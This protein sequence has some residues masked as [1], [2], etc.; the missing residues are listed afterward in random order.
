[1][2]LITDCGTPI[3]SPSSIW[4]RFGRLA[5]RGEAFGIDLVGGDHL[6]VGLGRG[7]GDAGDGAGFRDLAC[8]GRGP[9]KLVRLLMMSLPPSACIRQLAIAT[10]ARVRTLSWNTSPIWVLSAP[11][12]TTTTSPGPLGG[13][14]TIRRTAMSGVNGC[15]IRQTS[16]A[17]TA[18]PAS[19]SGCP[20]SAKPP[21]R[22]IVCAHRLLVPFRVYRPGRLQ[23]PSSIGV[24]SDRRFVCPCEQ[25]RQR[26]LHY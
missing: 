15:A 5:D 24:A 26:S 7:L 21:P 25:R 20:Q 8:C 1:M 11:N 12:S 6:G 2:R 16:C 17:W 18:G 19:A 13:N 22:R 9:T 23:R 4:V 10:S 14:Q 3:C